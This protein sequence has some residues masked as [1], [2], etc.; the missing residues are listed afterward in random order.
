MTRK[1]FF[2]V[3]VQAIADA[4]GAILWFSVRC[5]GS[6]HDSAAFSLTQL[7]DLIEAMERVGVHF[8]GDDAYKNGEAMLCPYRFADAPAGSD[9]D[10]YNYYQSLTRQPIER[11]FGMVE[12]RWGILWRRLEVRTLTLHPHRLTH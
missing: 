5:P 10:A 1:G 12:R 7:H 6:V 3:N 8:V 2:A 4:D 9:R 11:A